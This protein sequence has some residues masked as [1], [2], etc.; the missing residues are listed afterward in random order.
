V[1]IENADNNNEKN[2]TFSSI[3]QKI[4]NKN[5]N[6]ITFVKIRKG[7]TTLENG[8]DSKTVNDGLTMNI[9]YSGLN[10]NKKTSL[11]LDNRI[12]QFRYSDNVKSFYKQVGLVG[13]KATNDNVEI[14]ARYDDKNINTL[15]GNAKD[16]LNSEIL[17]KN[18]DLVENTHVVTYNHNFNLGPFTHIYDESQDNAKIANSDIFKKNI[19]DKLLNNDPI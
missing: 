1:N 5:D 13:D 4:H 19:V 15:I 7:R 18:T 10:D 9:R 8:S 12:L 17:N 2:R 6:L 14:Y 16:E 3:L 11:T